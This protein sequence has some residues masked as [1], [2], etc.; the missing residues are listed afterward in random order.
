MRL[1]TTPIICKEEI[2]KD[3]L[4]FRRVLHNNLFTEKREN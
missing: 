2:C 1:S 3:L 4:F